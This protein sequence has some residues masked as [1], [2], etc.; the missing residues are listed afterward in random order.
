MYGKRNYNS[1]TTTTTSRFQFIHINKLF[2]LN[3]KN[4]AKQTEFEICEKLYLKF[5]SN[6]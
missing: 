4:E 2:F 5:E 6:R 1:D 3:K